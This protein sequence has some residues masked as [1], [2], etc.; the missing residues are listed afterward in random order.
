MFVEPHLNANTTHGQL[1]VKNSI[2]APTAMGRCRGGI[3]TGALRIDLAKG[4]PA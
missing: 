4:K 1:K 3:A 2:Y